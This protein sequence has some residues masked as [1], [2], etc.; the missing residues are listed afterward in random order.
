MSDPVQAIAEGI[1]LNCGG[2]DDVDYAGARKAMEHLTAAGLAVVPRVAN[3]Q[4]TTF[5]ERLG[6]GEAYAEDLWL[7]MVQIAQGEDVT[8]ILDLYDATTRQGQP[9]EGEG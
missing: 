6:C 7:G 4:M 2:P 9:A 5:A 3:R 1:T 8:E